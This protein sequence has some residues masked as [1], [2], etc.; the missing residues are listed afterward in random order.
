LPETK[1]TI[2]RQPGSTLGL[3]EAFARSETELKS[4]WESKIRAL[5]AKEKVALWGAGAK[6]VTFANLI[7]SQRRWVD[8]IVDLN[9][10]KQGHYVPGTGH[11][12]VSY[13]DLMA[14]GVKSAILMNPNYRQENLAL[15]QAASADVRLIE[16]L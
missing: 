11:P 6:G 16:N 12:I 5:A 7:D 2:S 1:P 9:P 14:R 3:A 8:C 10:L 15:L 13:Q 4:D